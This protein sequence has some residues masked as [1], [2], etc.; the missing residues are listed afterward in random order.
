MIVENLSHEEYKNLKLVSHFFNSVNFINH[1]KYKCDEVQY[2]VFKDSKVRFGLVIGIKDGIIYT[3]FSAPF[4][5]FSY[6]KNDIKHHM[7]SKA[8]KALKEYLLLNNFK[9]MSIFLPPSIYDEQNSA[10]IITALLMGGFLIDFVDINH[11][12]NLRKFNSNYID[13]V[14]YGAKK[15]LKISLS[16][17]LKFTSCISIEEKTTAYDIIKKNRSQR[18]FPLKLKLKDVLE[19]ANLTESY[20]FIVSKQD[21]EPIASAIC[22]EVQNDV[23]QVIYWGGLVEYGE[24]KPINFLSYKI[25]EYFKG[26]GY[27]TVDIGP[28]S[29]RGVVNFGLSE[30][31]ESIGCDK[32]LKFHLTIKGV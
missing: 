28:S 14:Q 11:S 13:K 29:E 21:G 22:Y 23:V 6:S 3:P 30:F 20:F 15:S 4:G 17:S 9:R 7:F 10:K 18:G 32:H 5:G 19:T 26:I 16:K 1:N 2:L 12:Y 8:V 31:K 25:F 27:Q 24:Y